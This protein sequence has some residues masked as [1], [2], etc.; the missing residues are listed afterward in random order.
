MTTKRE[1]KK[2]LT[3]TLV[4]R[5]AI[6]NAMIIA[7]VK[8]EAT[9]EEREERNGDTKTQCQWLAEVVEGMNAFN[10]ADFDGEFVDEGQYADLPL[11][12]WR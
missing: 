9:I 2:K 12:T 7:K 1:L 11:C 5:Q 3:F 10:Q 6:L 8:L 4:E